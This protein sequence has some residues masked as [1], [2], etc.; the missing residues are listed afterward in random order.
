MK[1]LMF[2][3]VLAGF[4]G[5]VLC[6]SPSATTQKTSLGEWDEGWVNDDTYRFISV[7][8]DPGGNLPKACMAAELMAMAQ[9]IEKLGQSGSTLV[10]GKVEYTKYKGVIVKELQGKVKG[11]KVVYRSSDPKTKSCKVAYEISEPGLK[12]K[13][14]QT[15]DKYR[16]K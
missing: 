2:A 13:V 16:G 14:I 15:V 6:G 5:Y 1:K 9:A 12:Q 3:V 7:G 8:K 11:G 10:Q 4:A